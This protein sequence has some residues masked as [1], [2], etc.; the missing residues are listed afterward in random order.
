MDAATK[1]QIKLVSGLSGLGLG[2]LVVGLLLSN[3]VPPRLELRWSYPP[4]QL[5]EVV[6]EISMK[7]NLSQ[8]WRVWTNVTG[9]NRVALPD[10]PAQAFFVI[11]KTFMA[12]DTNNAIYWDGKGN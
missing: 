2:A 5:G 11:T 4:D 12:N 3:P 6:F 7:T 8:P 9:T 10:G 1:D